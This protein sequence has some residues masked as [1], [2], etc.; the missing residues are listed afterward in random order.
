MCLLIGVDAIEEFALSLRRRATDL[1]VSRYM[2]VVPASFLLADRARVAALAL[3]RFMLMAFDLFCC[4]C[5]V[6]FSRRS[7]SN[8]TLVR[9]YRIP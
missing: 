6:A 9:L 7:E 5:H 4:I 3:G 1:D 2:M 8:R